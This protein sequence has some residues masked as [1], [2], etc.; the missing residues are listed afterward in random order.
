MCGGAARGVGRHQRR[1]INV[2]DHLCVHRSDVGDH[3][4]G[5]ADATMVEETPVIDTVGRADT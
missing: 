5:A 4:D 3:R 1:A 2:R